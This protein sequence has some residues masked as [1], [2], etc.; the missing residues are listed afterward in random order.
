MYSTPNAE[1]RSSVFALKD[2]LQVVGASLLI[3]LCAQIQIPLFFTP[4]PLSGQTFAALLAGALLG[5]RK[6]AL[7]VLLY[8][9]EGCVGLPVFTSGPLGFARLVGP[10]GG[11]IVGFVFEAYCVGFFLEK[12]KNITAVKTFAILCMGCAIQLGCG[13]LWL[14]HFVGIQSVWAL[15]VV[16]FVA[17]E[18][19]KVSLVGL[20]CRA[21][22]AISS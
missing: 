9:L 6:G 19:F 21:R 18:L 14:I 16:P 5:S 4:V 7:S 15:G 20:I 8:I 13:A 2:L 10:T 3:A 17:G 1:T 12:M 11:Y 22:K